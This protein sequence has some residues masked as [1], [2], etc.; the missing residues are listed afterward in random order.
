[1]EE[2]E[3]AVIGGGPAGIM[4]AIAASKN[5]SNVIIL[6]K[7]P[8][9]GRKLL[10]TGG[11]RCNITNAKPIKKLLKF[12]PQKNFLKHSFYTLTNEYLLSFFENKGLNFIEEDNNRIFPESE[13]SSDILKILTDYLE[14]VVISY[15]FEVKSISDDFVINDKIKADKIIIATGG[16]TYPQTGCSID[17]YF[18]T[19]QPLT[20]IKY[21]LVPLVTKKDLSSI[22]GVTLYDVVISY[23]K[24]KVQGNVLIS[25]VGLTG[26]GIIDLSND[27]SESISYNLL[28]NDDVDVDFEIAI[29][30]CPESS[31]EELQDKF[32]QDFQ[33]KGKTMIK[34][35]LKLFLTNKFIDFFLDE[36]NL[37]GETQLSRI[38]KKSKNRLIENLK[39]FTFN[40][41]GFND[42]LAKVTIGGIDLDS[43]NPK[44][45]ESTVIPDLYFAGE[46]LDLHGP[47]GGYNLKIAFSTGYLAGLSASEKKKD[48]N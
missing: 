6:E 1:M 9:L 42:K 16:I 2:Y 35:Y 23:K 34:N 20:D 13:K 26:P 30:L 47:T 39:R 28:E 32:N 41:T 27:I 36:I 19:S 24:T 14:D 25:H 40:I 12:Y 48:R 33:T 43:I 45:M 44:T 11:G 22:A 37:D 3:I 46:V 18:L 15:N 8:K 5:S 4:A 31:R 17:N 29:D 10:T 7:N 38:N 21:G